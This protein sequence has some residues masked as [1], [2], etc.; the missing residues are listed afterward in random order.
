MDKKTLLRLLGRGLNK[1][2][3]ASLLMCLGCIILYIMASM[4]EYI[5][6]FHQAQFWIWFFVILIAAWAIGLGASKMVLAFCRWW[7]QE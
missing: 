3:D 2:W 4:V 1:A 6:G 7:S 5:F